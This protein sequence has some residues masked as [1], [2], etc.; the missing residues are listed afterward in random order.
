V[1]CVEDSRA[2]IRE[3]Q[4][5]PVAE[6]GQM[7]ILSGLRAGDEVIIFGQD[8]VHENDLVNVNWHQ[9]AQRQ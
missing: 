1:F 7:A 2:R 6:A 4:P 3:V 9:W 8:A 5:G